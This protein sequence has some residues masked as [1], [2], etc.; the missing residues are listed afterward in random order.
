M[1]KDHRVIASKAAPAA[2]RSKQAAKDGRKSRT[3]SLHDDRFR[4]LKQ[5]CGAEE[6]TISEVVDAL[7]QSFLEEYHRR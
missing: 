3:M 4:E 6:W 2:L 5:I 7:I 1:A